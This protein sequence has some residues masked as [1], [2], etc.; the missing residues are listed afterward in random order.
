MPKKPI[1]KFNRVGRPSKADLAAKSQQ[2]PKGASSANETPIPSRAE[3]LQAIIDAPDLRC[4]YCERE[5]KTQKLLD[6]HEKFCADKVLLQER[7]KSASVKIAAEHKILNPLTSPL[8]QKS[9]SE[10][11]PIANVELAIAS[12]GDMAATHFGEHWRLSVEEV[13]NL[14]RVWKP[15][16]ERYLPTFNNPI[17]AALGATIFIIG[18]KVAKHAELGRR[19]KG[20]AVNSGPVGVRKIDNDEG[21]HPEGGSGIDL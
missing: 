20:S 15:I 18:P 14:A 11:I 5:F 1:R 16:I 10:S 6:A 3:R 7:E 4:C 21:I 9:E 13:K 19:R 17:F 12:M 8:T 2:Q